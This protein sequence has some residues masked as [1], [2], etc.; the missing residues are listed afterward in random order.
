MNTVT[1]SLPVA[2][3]MWIHPRLPESSSLARRIDDAT[4]GLDG[5]SDTLDLTLIVDELAMMHDAID[6]LPKRARIVV[7]QLMDG[8]KK[9]SPSNA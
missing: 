1:V 2:A 5:A 9:D 3:W 4:Y 7:L 6:R 8:T